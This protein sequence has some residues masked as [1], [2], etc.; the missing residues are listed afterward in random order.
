MHLTRVSSPC[1]A[2]PPVTACIVKPG[3]LPGVSLSVRHRTD[4]WPLTYPA[5][6]T[7]K[8]WH[9]PYTLSCLPNYYYK[10]DYKEGS[11]RA[12]RCSVASNGSCMRSSWH[13]LEHCTCTVP[14]FHEVPTHGH[15]KCLALT[16]F[17]FVKL[18]FTK[19]AHYYA[20]SFEFLFYQCYQ[21]LV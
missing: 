21:E 4:L 10:G 5:E 11:S 7:N 18:H 19:T 17:N 9:S 12:Q 8:L 16:T 3:H 20:D 1:R 15:F 14:C 2:L 6:V 13:V